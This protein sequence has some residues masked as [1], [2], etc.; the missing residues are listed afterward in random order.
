MI[1]SRE[2]SP[3]TDSDYEAFLWIKEN[4]PTNATF[5]VTYADA[6]QWIPVFTQRR[7]SPLFINQNEKIY[8]ENEIFGDTVIPLMLENPN[9]PLALS[10]LKKQGI[11][12]IYI[13][14]KT[15]FSRQQLVP[16]L[17]DEPNYEC[18]YMQ[19]NV[20]IFQLRKL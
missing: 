7:V 18:V 12:H 4:T 10:L 2:L 13:G 5:F 9:D 16:D 6:G 20:W 8:M 17:F 19:N 1:E 14:S 3:I 11:T 15:I